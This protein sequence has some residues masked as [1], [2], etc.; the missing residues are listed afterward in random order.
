MILYTVISYCVIRITEKYSQ[1]LIIVG[2]L[3]SICMYA[4]GSEKIRQN[5]AFFKFM[6]IIIY[7][8]KCMLW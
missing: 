6:F 3:V 1:V 2:N 7:L 5:R 8:A 4:T